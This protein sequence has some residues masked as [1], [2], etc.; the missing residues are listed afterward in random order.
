MRADERIFD[1]KVYRFSAFGI[2]SVIR[3]LAARLRRGG[4]STRTVKSTQ[5]GV[6]GLTLY[7]RSVKW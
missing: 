7:A 4:Y 5:A 2:P 1:G 3:E 6:Q